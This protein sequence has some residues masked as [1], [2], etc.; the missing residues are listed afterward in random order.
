MKILQF[1]KNEEFYEDQSSYV[2]TT[3]A[4]LMPSPVHFPPN[5]PIKERISFTKKHHFHHEYYCQSNSFT[6]MRY[7]ICGIKV[8]LQKMGVQWLLTQMRAFHSNEIGLFCTHP[9]S[10]WPLFLG[11]RK[12]A[13]RK[14]SFE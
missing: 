10:L 14:L 13:S 12:E 1:Y 7:S 3:C 6:D 4:N 2:W 5:S 11:G 8:E 9:L